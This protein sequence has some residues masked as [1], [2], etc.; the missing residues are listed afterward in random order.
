MKNYGYI[1]IQKPEQDV[2][3]EITALLEKEVPEENIY[4]DKWLLGL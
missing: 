4:K 3:M 1:M 2:G